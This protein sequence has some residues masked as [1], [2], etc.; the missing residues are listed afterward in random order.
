[1][2]LTEG[3]HNRERAGDDYRR[4]GCAEGAENA[5]LIDENGYADL[6]SAK[7]LKKVDPADLVSPQRAAE[8]I[9]PLLD[10]PA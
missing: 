2:Q 7:I 6:G 8:M 1:L 4:A 3:Q 5:K 10:A 9:A